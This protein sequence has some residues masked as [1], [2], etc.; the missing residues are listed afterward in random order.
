MERWDKVLEYTNKVINSG[1]YK[2]LE[3]DKYKAYPT[4]VPEENSETIFAVRY[5]KDVDY[6]P[7][8]RPYMIGSMYAEIDDDGWEMYP[9]DSYLRLLDLHPEDLRQTFIHKQTVKNRKFWFIYNSKNNT[10]VKVSVTKTGTGYTINNPEGYQSAVV[11][12]EEYHGGTAYTVTAADGTKYYGRVEE[13]TD[14]RND[15]RNIIYTNVRYKRTSS[16]M[17]SGSFASCRNVSQ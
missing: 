5:T 12:K 6:L 16:I 3:G 17:V 10:Y 7:D 15:Y 14:T 11:T 1:R 4:F 8:Y 13:E 9:S 2:L